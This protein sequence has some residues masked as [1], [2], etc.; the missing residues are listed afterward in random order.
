M[1]GLMMIS[2]LKEHVDVCGLGKMFMNLMTYR[3]VTQN[4]HEFLAQVS[5]MPS[6][7]TKKGEKKYNCGHFAPPIKGQWTH[8]NIEEY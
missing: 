3:I 8:N 1:K 7:P 4:Q 6:H 2:S 5:V